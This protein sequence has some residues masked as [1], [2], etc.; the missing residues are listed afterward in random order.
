MARCWWYAY[1]PSFLIVR[2]GTVGLVSQREKVRPQFLSPP[3]RLLRPALTRILPLTRLPPEKINPLPTGSSAPPIVLEADL[4]A[5]GI[6]P[7]VT[8]PRSPLSVIT[9]R[10]RPARDHHR[11][12]RRS[13]FTL[14]ADPEPGPRNRNL[15][16]LDETS[17]LALRRPQERRTVV[18]GGPLRRCHLPARRRFADLEAGRAMGA[19]ALFLCPRCEDDG[20]C[21][22]TALSSSLLAGHLSG[23]PMAAGLHAENPRRAGAGP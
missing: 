3:D 12:G 14:R 17:I 23:R 9:H 4:R 21:G 18:Y 19:N 16:P 8:Q 6:G 10:F 15:R 22:G 7:L 13:A 20:V 5:S 2:L 11:P 1:P